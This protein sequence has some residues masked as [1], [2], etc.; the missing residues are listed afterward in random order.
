MT[1]FLFA[2][3]FFLRREYVSDISA[4]KKTIQEASTAV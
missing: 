2:A 3:P 4:S 1:G